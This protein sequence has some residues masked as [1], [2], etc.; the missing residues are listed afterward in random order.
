MNKTYALWLIMATATISVNNYVQ[1]KNPVVSGLVGAGL[2]ALAGEALFGD[3]GAA[4]CA[5]FGAAAGAATA[6]ADEPAPV[7]H[8]Y[9]VVYEEP[10]VDTQ[11][12]NDVYRL[13][14]HVDALRAENNALR[15]Q[16]NALNAENNR[17][18]REKSELER[19]HVQKT[20]QLSSLQRQVSDLRHRND[21][22]SSYIANLEKDLAKFRSGNI[23]MSFS[24]GTR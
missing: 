20:E 11:V 16:N 13:Q 1:A 22:L 15:N 4:P 8:H 19:F 23:A 14:R 9:H 6:M 24:V 17:L 21:V 12:Y 7:E 18:Q 10:Y 2:G 3:D 5:L